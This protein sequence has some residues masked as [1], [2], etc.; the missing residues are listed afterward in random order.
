MGDSVAERQLRIP[1][2]I[3]Q[4]RGSGAT[5]GSLSLWQ[6]FYTTTQGPRLVDYRWF[7][8][9]ERPHSQ[10]KF[11]DLEKG[12]TRFGY[13]PNPSPANQDAQPVCFVEDRDRLHGPE[14]LRDGTRT[15]R[16]HGAHRVPEDSATPDA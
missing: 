5:S 9:L 15:W 13:L 10:A 4:A 12:L 7:L 6:R 8:A 14:G 16:P 2:A 3:E 11:P 1:L